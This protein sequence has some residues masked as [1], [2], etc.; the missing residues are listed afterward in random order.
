MNLGLKVKTAIV[1]GASMGLG[2]A[3]AK[4]LAREGCNVTICARG[5]EA[6]LRAQGE[7][8]AGAEGADCHA[9]RADILVMGV[10]GVAVKSHQDV[11]IVAGGEYGLH[12]DAGLGPGG[13]AQDLGGEGG[14]GQGVIADLGR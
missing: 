13:T 7:V 5:E 11:D 3:T 8:I 14:E 9:V 12:G 6:L 10:V 2:L 4:E 1:T